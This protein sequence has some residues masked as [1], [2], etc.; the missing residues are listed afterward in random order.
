MEEGRS[1]VYLTNRSDDPRLNKALIKFLATH[2]FVE[3]NRVSMISGADR[4]VQV[5]KG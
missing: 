5:M 2:F 3:K 4:V 1:R